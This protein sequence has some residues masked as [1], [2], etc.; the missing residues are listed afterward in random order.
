[1]RIRRFSPVG[2]ALAGLLAACGGEA[3]APAPSPSEAAPPE[4]P[5]GIALSD[6]RVQLP[7][8]AGRPGVAYFTVTQGSGA[9]RAIAA[10]HVEG[11]GR[12]EMHATRDEGGV[13]RMEQV[14]SVPVGAGKSVKFAPGGNHVMLFDLAPALAAGTATE[15]TVT[16]DNGDKA[17]IAAPVQAAGTGMDMTP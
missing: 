2:L 5:P 15:L 17:T 7:A 11:A 12:A 13:S 16:F 8:V 6:A 14:A 4:N 9:P 1:M 3:P 10:V